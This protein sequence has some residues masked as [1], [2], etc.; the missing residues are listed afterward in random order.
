MC[1]FVLWSFLNPLECLL[2]SSYSWSLHVFIQAIE[3]NWA[4]QVVPVAKNLPANAGDA[5]DMG[6]LPGSGR[7]PG[8]GHGNPLQY[9]CLENPMDRRAWG[10]TVH[11]VTQSQT[12][13]ERLNT[14][15]NWPHVCS[16]Q[17]VIGESWKFYKAQ[18]GATAMSNSPL[19]QTLMTTLRH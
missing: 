5:R 14:P 6:L 3:G 1:V 17:F 19:E 16:D 8:G 7:S 13:L 10:A 4:S 12:W 2:F 9:S 15:R 18:K 11:R